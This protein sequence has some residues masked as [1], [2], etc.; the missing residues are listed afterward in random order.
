[1]DQGEDSKGIGVGKNRVLRLMRENGLLGRGD[2]RPWWCRV[3]TS[4][5]VTDATRFKLGGAGS[6]WRWITASQTLGWHVAKKGDRWAALEPIRQGV[7]T[8]MDG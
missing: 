5:G 8:H 3:C 1:M 4:C 2:Q 7:R 6:S